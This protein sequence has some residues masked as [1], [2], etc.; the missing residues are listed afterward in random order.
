MKTKPYLVRC[1]ITVLKGA[2]TRRFDA[3]ALILLLSGA[4]V[5]RADLWCTAYYP[6]WEQN[7]TMPATAIDFSTVTHV[8][9]FSLLPNAD[10]SLNSTM[11][12]LSP[13]NSSNIV[14]AAHAANRKVLLCVGGEDTSFQSATS[15]QYITNFVNNLTNL[16]AARGYDGIDVDW[17]PLEAADATQF[18]NLVKRLRTAL[19]AF[20]PPRL[21]TVAVPPSA[22]VS[23]I[24]SVS[25]HF[26]QIN[27]M[28]YDLSGAYGGW[29]TWFNS[30]LYNGSYNFPST[31]E[32]VPSVDE[33]TTDF[34]T[35]GVPAG[36]LGIGVAF[37]GYIWSGGAGTTTGGAALPRQAWTTA[38]AV[39]RASYN[40]IM[41]LGYPAGN[42]HYD[43]NAQAAYISVDNGGSSNDRFIS[44]DDERVCQSKVSYARNRGLGGVMIW[45]IAQ[46]YRTNGPAPLMGAIKQALATPGKLTVQR[47]GQNLTLS[48]RSAPLG[49]YRVEWKSNLTAASWNT[50][51]VTNMA[52]TGGVMQVTT[53]TPL[54]PAQGFYRV[55][56]PQ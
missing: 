21:L 9:H 28:T 33:I 25:A 2:F 27:L 47:G 29:V 20:T 19:N 7:S 8:I 13:A 5:A 17:E 23:L 31:G 4:G 14:T 54:N 3:F 22:P 42:F 34:I 18:T 10:G 26:D 40:E 53:Q 35:G 55:K 51:L 16:M 49:S 43:T 52:G 41:A 48:F 56:S 6:G 44:Y 38:P 46:D 37:T 39:S 24:A 45:E 50:L 12:G 36:K 15:P 32:P 1:L 11:N 30:P